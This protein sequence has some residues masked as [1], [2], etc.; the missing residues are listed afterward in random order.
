MSGGSKP[1]IRSELRSPRAAAIAGI[2]FALLQLGGMILAPSVE[3]PDEFNEEWLVTWHSEASLVLTLVSFSG[4]AFLWFTGVIRDLVGDREDRLF[5]TVFLGS[6]ILYAGMLFV[7]AA[8]LG[9][10]FR[11]YP[12]V[13][14]RRFTD[15]DVFIF[16]FTLMKEILGTYALRMAGVYMMSI[17]S[18]LARTGV[19]PRW[20]TLLSTLVALGFLLFAGVIRAARYVFPGWVLL[21]SVY[22]LVRNYRGVENSGNAVQEESKGNE[23][24]SPGWVDALSAYGAGGRVVPSSNASSI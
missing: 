19:L 20:V 14:S 15:N 9:A 24:E 23:L 4:I 22:I 12:L 11:S 7:W 17:S 8:A 1:I 21:V 5:A 18:L 3:I 2:L 6:S 16:G 10:I 13:V